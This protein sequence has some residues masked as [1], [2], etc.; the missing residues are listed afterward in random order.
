VVCINEPEKRE[1]FLRSEEKERSK[2][3][4]DTGACLIDDPLPSFLAV[5]ILPKKQ[6][7]EGVR[8]VRGEEAE[9]MSRAGYREITE[10]SFADPWRVGSG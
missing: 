1:R 9:R 3:N 7:S 4:V 8:D 6:S 10:R 2:G 5:A